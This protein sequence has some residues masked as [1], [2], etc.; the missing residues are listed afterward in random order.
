MSLGNLSNCPNCGQLFIKSIRSVC[1]DCYK[2]IEAQYELVYKFIRNKE[3]RQS[4]ILEVST[5]TGVSEKQIRQFIREGRLRLADFPNLGYPC[6]RCGEEII[7]EGKLCERCKKELDREI[8]LSLDDDYRRQE[9]L[10][11]AK[12]QGGFLSKN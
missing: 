9:L 7:T 10:K 4:T 5:A 12:E 3:N 11:K 8:R 2:K 6:E 1:N